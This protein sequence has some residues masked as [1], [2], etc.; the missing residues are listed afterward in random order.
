[1]PSPLITKDS[2]YRDPSGVQ[3]VVDSFWEARRG[4]VP[5]LTVTALFLCTAVTIACTVFPRTPR[6]FI[7]MTSGRPLAD[8]AAGASPFIFLCA[9]VVVF[10][11]PRFGYGLGLLAGL[12]ALPWFVWTELS[13]YESS[14]IFLNGA[15]GV[16][17][18]DPEFAVFV[19]LKLLSVALIVIAIVCSSLRLLPARWLLSNSPVCQRTWPTF[20]V[21]FL[22]LGLWLFHS[23]TPYR[24]PLIMDAVSAEFRIL[25]IEK[26]GLRFQETGMSAYQDR[27]FWVWRNDRRLFQYRFETRLVRGVMPQTAYEHAAAFVKSPEL[28]KLH[29]R[30]VEAV[31]SWNAEGWYVVLKDSQ[32]FTFTSEYRTAPPREVTDLFYEVEKLP[33]EE[34]GPRPVRDVCLGFCYGPV[35][36][37]GFQYSNQ[38]CFAL[39]RGT[40]ECR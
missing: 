1:M 30:P 39:T 15:V 16:T 13:P 35:A 2:S 14:W 33:A 29:T 38:P 10:L 37:L 22:V 26:R 6:G 31:R 3:S 4:D 11:R 12:S 18:D 36:A 8:V 19:K 21:G 32:L 24:V 23:A 34:E 9:C 17:P 7:S 20:A 28:W 5:K 40:T 25:H 27:V